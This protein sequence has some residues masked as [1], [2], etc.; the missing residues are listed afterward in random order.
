GA[1]AKV[2]SHTRDAE[3]ARRPQETAQQRM[4]TV[5]LHELRKTQKARPLSR[6]GLK[7]TA[8]SDLL[9]A[10]RSFSEGGSHTSDA[11]NARRPQETAQQPMGTVSLHELRKTQKARPL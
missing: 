1:S 5:S 7:N 10:R 6:S 8:G 9:P 4:G 11:E 3:N 2:G